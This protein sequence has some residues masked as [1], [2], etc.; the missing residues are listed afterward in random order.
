EPF[1]ATVLTEP[2]PEAAHDTT[3]S[4]VSDVDDSDLS[5][6]TEELPNHNDVILESE[7]RVGGNA[8]LTE[9]G[10]EALAPVA[11]IETATSLH[12]ES[13]GFDTSLITEVSKPETNISECKTEITEDKAEVTE[14]KT[15][16]TEPK[17]W[18]SRISSLLSRATKVVTTPVKP[19]ADVVAADP[20]SDISATSTPGVRSVVG[21]EAST[22][23]S[24]PAK[25]KGTMDT[26]D[27]A[28]SS[29]TDV[30]QAPVIT[31]H[32]QTDAPL[33]YADILMTKPDVPTFVHPTAQKAHESQAAF[34]KKSTV[35]SLSSVVSES[36]RSPTARGRTT[37]ENQY[38]LMASLETFGEEGSCDSSEEW[39]PATPSLVLARGPRF[40]YQP[41]RR[42]EPTP[43]SAGL[44]AEGP[45]TISR[46][47]L[48]TDSSS[49][50]TPTVVVATGPSF[51]Y[52]GRADATS[53]SNCKDIVSRGSG[54]VTTP[55]VVRPVAEISD[56][57]LESSESSEELISAPTT[58][59]ATGPSFT[60]SGGTQA[61][62]KPDVET[63]V[64]TPRIED[65][66]D[67]KAVSSI[68]SG[69]SYKDIVSRGSADVCRPVVVRPVAEISDLSSESSESSEELVSAPT[70]VVATGP[71][72][73]YTGG[74]Q[75]VKKPVVQTPVEKQRVE[76]VP[77]H[78]A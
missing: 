73:T 41:G 44:V 8:R 37:G 14:P 9:P 54:D 51:S 75:V 52:G 56:L 22:E 12:I 27:T 74:T 50:K 16:V 68:T 29:T 32:L 49:P 30:H 25:S 76:D 59:V 63:P 34:A 70:T 58:V 38:R 66:P 48:S 40:T 24:P 5:S 17:T 13:V 78:K 62:K 55:V 31:G 21:A 1:D 20:S 64:E 65:V 43:T 3:S 4:D 15:E 2:V 28:R 36:H 26:T 47:K 57:S 53:G 67:H 61:V 71:S 11:A 46:R 45:P 10:V 42:V 6:E 72:F 35:S 69:P 77:D 33:S 23:A 19:P 18:A 60:Y 39:V 7:S